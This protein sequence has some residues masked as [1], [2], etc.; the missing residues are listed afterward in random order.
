MGS[1]AWL[2]LSSV[3]AV[4]VMLREW[5]LHLRLTTIIRD[6]DLGDEKKPLLSPSAYIKITGTHFHRQTGREYYTIKD[7]HSFLIRKEAIIKDFK[8]RAGCRNGSQ[9]VVALWMAVWLLPMFIIADYRRGVH[10]LLSIIGGLGCMLWTVV[11]L[12]PRFPENFDIPP[13]HPGNC[14]IESHAPGKEHV[15]DFLKGR[16]VAEV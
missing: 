12:P 3:L 4:V 10:Y 16:K 5:H 9:F 6:D 15:E 7:T 8:R 13:A 11:S 14:G 1:A 2:T